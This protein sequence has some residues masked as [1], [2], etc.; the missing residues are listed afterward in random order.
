ME[1]FKIDI[2]VKLVEIQQQ[3]SYHTINLNDIKTDRDKILF[4]GVEFKVTELFIKSLCKILKIPFKYAMYINDVLFEDNINTLITEKSDLKVLICMKD[5]NTLV[6]VIA[7]KKEFYLPEI[8]YLL[9]GVKIREELREC[10]YIEDYGYMFLYYTDSEEYGYMIKVPM[11]LADNKITIETIRKKDFVVI[12]D[13]KPT[14]FSLSVKKSDDAKL[15]DKLIDKLNSHV[16]NEDLVFLNGYFEGLKT[17]KINRENIN[18]LFTKVFKLNAD[19]LYEFG[20]ED[21]ESL[22]YEKSKTENPDYDY[23]TLLEMLQNVDINAVGL[24]VYYK[25]INN[26]WICKLYGNQMKMQK[27]IEQLLK[28]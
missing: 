16:D 12:P 7:L 10:W 20:I 3:Y 13:K 24:D 6:N 9:E 2:D 19:L 23:L 27:S 21:I 14:K 22:K 18:K 28:K 15:A 26:R 1:R 8:D 17:C 11:F 4:K 5:K 25:L